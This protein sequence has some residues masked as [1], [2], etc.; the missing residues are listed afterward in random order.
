MSEQSK[1]VKFGFQLAAVDATGSTDAKLY[2]TMLE[3]A[4]LG[5][6]LGYE[7]AWVVEHHF[8][9]YFPQP[10][11]IAILSHVAAKCPGI[12]LGAMVLV[13]P[14]YQPVRLAGEIS[15]LSHLSKG[16]LHLGMGRGNAPMEYEAFGVPM[17]EAKQ[18]FEE[19]WRIIELAMKGESFTFQGKNL[20]VD[21]E[22]T[23][24]PHPVTSKI[25]FYGAIGNPASA[26][27]IADLGLAPISNGSLPFEV[28]RMVMKTWTE[29]AE[30][31]GLDTNV[32]KPIGVTLILADTDEEAIEL[33]RKYMPRW[34]EVQV[35]H[36]AFDASRHNDLPDYRPFA[37]T[38]E[39]R[40]RMTNP[41]NLGP[42]FEVSLIGSPETIKQ[43]LQTYIDIGFNSFI[44]QA[45]TPDIPQSVRTDWLTRF[46]REIAP[47]FSDRYKASPQMAA[48]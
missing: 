22:I 34:F 21:R 37:E 25:N 3:D 29:I 15:I 35:E 41:D 46:A 19:T 2:Q 39:R 28:Q 42:L 20:S 5:Y 43:K 30:S 10:S 31:K 45:A 24:R 6:D 14:W 12:G 44:L 47:A 38:H 13:T 1:S 33:G 40:I 26:T 32:D 7:I 11:P 23:L 17:D 48:E 36:Y 8:S 16:D 4:Q 27:K 18:R 9:D